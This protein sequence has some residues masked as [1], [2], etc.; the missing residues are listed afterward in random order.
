MKG[1]FHH[2]NVQSIDRKSHNVVS[3]KGLEIYEE[4]QAES[5]KNKRLCELI[6]Y[7]FKKK[8]KSEL[9]PSLCLPCFSAV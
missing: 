1:R 6:N 8:K 5:G 9:C 3:D 4:V 2:S 7:K